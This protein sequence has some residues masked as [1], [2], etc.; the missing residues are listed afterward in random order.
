MI[1]VAI[2]NV[3]NYDHYPRV[4]PIKGVA[5]IQGWLLSKVCPLFKGGSYQRCGNYS[6][7]ATIKGVVTIQGWLP[8]KVWPL[9]KG[10]YY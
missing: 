7:V 2:D 9:F 1:L 5:T 6:R 4:A 8:L 10:G 3:T